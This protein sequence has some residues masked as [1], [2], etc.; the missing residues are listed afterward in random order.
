MA[1]LLSFAALSRPGAAAAAE[2]NQFFAFGDSTLDT[3]YF[4]YHTTGSTAADQG[5]ANAVAQGATGGYAGNGVMNTVTL[6]EKFGLTIAPIDAPGGGTN[7]ANGGATTIPNPEP[8]Y[9]DNI[10]TIQQIKTYL[11]SVNG[12][13]NPNALYL[14]KT[15]DNDATYVSNQTPT[16]IADHPDYLS[17]VAAALAP[18]VARL[19]AAGA[20]TI[21]VRNSY[22]S[23][24]FAGPGGDIAVNYDAAYARSRLLGTSEWAD[25]AA[26]GVHFIPADNDSLFRYIAHNPRLFGFNSFTVLSTSAPYY[27]VKPACMCIL[28]PAQQREFLFIDGVHLTTAGQ[29]IEADYTYSLLIAPSEISLLAQSAVQGGWA[30][31]A[32][33]QG[34]IDP[35]GQH[36]GP[37]GFNVWASG[38]AY[39]LEVGN[40]SGFP[41]D[42][43]ASFGGSMGVDYQTPVG[44]IVGL[45]F[46]EGNQTQRF[47]SGGNFT[48]LDAA[49]SLYVAYAGRPLWGNAVL[50]YD[51]FQ[52]NVARLVP[53][54]NFN[55]QNN[56]NTN[57]Q[58]LAL[59]LRGG[60]DFCVGPVTTGPVAGMILQQAHVDSFTETG[61]SR[62]TA[63]SF[64]SQTQ[65]SFVTQVGWRV[66]ADM[67][68]WRPF[69][70]MNW[71]HEC[72]GN[73]RTVTASLTSVAAPSYSLDAAPVASD[74]ATLTFGAFYKLSPQV[75]LRGAASALFLT[76]QMTTCGG[77]LGLNVSF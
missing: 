44:V 35:I 58:S 40:E 70:E 21:V 62:V 52:D 14:I 38:G 20:N 56:G 1:A 55:D 13:A 29:T 30:R 33:I 28:T 23:A 48:Q 3:G 57:G 19:Q 47:S 74:W 27:D 26:A 67:D 60:R 36:C 68:Q 69:A 77:E 50:S 71:D 16:W 42:S 53:L 22:D 34:Q 65:N 51:Q 10:T 73:G 2:F 46:T 25:L 7:Y 76:P 49:P 59:A 18:E 75:M 12:V 54:G 64:G 8:D 17:G 32:T 66:W 43:G 24:V 5:I 37:C 63:L 72:A 61:V 39:S 9:P 6:A 31:A 11:H 45:A 4:R 15:G 41:H